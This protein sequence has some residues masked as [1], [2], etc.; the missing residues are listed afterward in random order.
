GVT[1]F[2]PTAHE[3]RPR[4]RDRFC[5]WLVWTEPADPRRLAL[6]RGRLAR[7]T[8]PP[9]AGL[10]APGRGRSRLSASV[11][12]VRAVRAL[13]DE[14]DQ[15]LGQLG[16][17][18][19]GVVHDILCLARERVALD[20]CVKRRAGR[21]KEQ[22]A[23]GRTGLP[24]ILPLCCVG[25]VGETL[26]IVDHVRRKLVNPI[27]LID[28]LLIAAEPFGSVLGKRTNVGPGYGADAR[29]RVVRGDDGLARSE[30]GMRPR[31]RVTLKPL[32][33]QALYD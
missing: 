14:P 3:K 8:P 26:R 16:C 24:V 1:W 4:K 22:P 17:A 7:A 29:A 23:L 6:R 13:A 15:L 31:S 9:R 19:L 5:S 12:A 21:R 33:R 2:E 25:H 30:C 10:L 27:H 18:C 32:S 11:L 28:P 20:D